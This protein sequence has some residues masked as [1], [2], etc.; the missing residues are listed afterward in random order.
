MGM[1]CQFLI[2][3]ETHI[4]I[5]ESWVEFQ[6][7]FEIGNSG[8]RLSSMAGSTIR[9]DQVFFR[10]NMLRLIAINNR[11]TVVVHKLVKRSAI[12]NT[13]NG[14]ISLAGYDSSIQVG[15]NSCP[16]GAFD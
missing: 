8:D 11:G 7:K 12:N 4:I 6:G 14:S 10:I 1:D 2:G 13:I 15:I 3:I 9:G 16:R 5:M